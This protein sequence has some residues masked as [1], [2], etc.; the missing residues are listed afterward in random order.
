MTLWLAFFSLF[1]LQEKAFTGTPSKSHIEVE[2][3]EATF[4]SPRLKGRNCQR[5]E[6]IVSFFALKHFNQVHFTQN[7][8]SFFYSLS[9]KN[10]ATC[11]SHPIRIVNGFSGSF[12]ISCVY[13][14]D[15]LSRQHFSADVPI[16]DDGYICARLYLT[17][18]YE[19]FARTIRTLL[20]Q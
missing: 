15:E 6:I 20:H 19:F 12:H 4:S 8:S 3:L 16:A 7:I 5:K 18:S 1:S 14:F 9:F 13:L 17:L 2:K 11:I 10:S